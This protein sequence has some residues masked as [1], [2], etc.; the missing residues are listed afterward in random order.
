MRNT[1]ETSPNLL[2][3]KKNKRTLTLLEILIAIAI[4]AISG[5]AIAWRMHG[6]IER[7]EFSFQIENLKTKMVASQKLALAM[8]ADWKAV[9]FEKNREWIFET[10]CDEGKKLAPMKLKAF[11]I[12][13]NEKPVREVLVFDFFSTGKISP[14][15]EL[16]FK[17][18]AHE[19]RWKLSE[20]FEKSEGKEGGPDLFE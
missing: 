19:I 8:Q 4:L 17:Y 7:K 13:L 3:L 15:G 12:F 6:A 14:Q 11:E 2:S 5:G 1:K 16:C 18:K 20:I 10:A 9:L